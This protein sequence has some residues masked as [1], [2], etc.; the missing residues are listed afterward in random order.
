MTEPT[1]EIKKQRIFGCNY[2][3][4]H[5][6]TTHRQVAGSFLQFMGKPPLPVIATA[7]DPRLF[8]LLALPLDSRILK[9]RE[10][11]PYVP[12][13]QCMSLIHNQAHN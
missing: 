9:H 11:P 5:M 3:N 13:A 8:R 12:T 6:S 1:E 7:P 10:C 4:F 2:S